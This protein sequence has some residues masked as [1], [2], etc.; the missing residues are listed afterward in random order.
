MVHLVMLLI[1]LGSV[2]TNN[3]TQEDDDHPEELEFVRVELEMSHQYL[4][5]NSSQVLKVFFP[6]ATTDNLII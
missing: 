3:M 2:L 4:S 5:Q 6:C 1:F